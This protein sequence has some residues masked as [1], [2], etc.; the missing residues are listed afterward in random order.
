MKATPMT[1]S[2]AAMAT[3]RCLRCCTVEIEWKASMRR[4]ARVSGRCGR[5]TL[6]CRLQWRLGAHG[7]VK[8]KGFAVTQKGI[9][10]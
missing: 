9:A 3:G 10:R 5:M 7:A 4:R 8:V 2:R 1:G 6:L